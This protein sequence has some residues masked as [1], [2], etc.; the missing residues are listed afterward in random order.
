M[1]IIFIII[2]SL[3]NFVGKMIV[4]NKVMFTRY[5]RLCWFIRN[6]ANLSRIIGRILQCLLHALIFSVNQYV[7]G[8]PLRSCCFL[9][10]QCP[11]DRIHYSIGHILLQTVRFRRPGAQ[12]GD[13]SILSTWIRN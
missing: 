3:Q 1:N 5:P 6:S 9:S 12:P 13:S 2:N 4:M 11:S 8:P 7:L 10:V